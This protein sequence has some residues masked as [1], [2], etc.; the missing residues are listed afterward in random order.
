[1]AESS[2]SKLVLILILTPDKGGPQ[3]KFFFFIAL[4][5]GT[6]M[7]VPGLLPGHQPVPVN[8]VPRD[9]VDRYSKIF[10]R[11]DRKILCDIS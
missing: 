7:R 9:V 5:R 1:M 8:A 3:F 4:S 10:R 2:K 11:A 6:P